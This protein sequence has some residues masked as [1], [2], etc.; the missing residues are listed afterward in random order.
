M[1][2]KII[3]ILNL[4]CNK[5]Y[6]QKYSFSARNWNSI[7]IIK[8]KILVELTPLLIDIFIYLTDIKISELYKDYLNE[9]NKEI[10]KGKEEELFIDISPK[11][12]ICPAHDCPLTILKQNLLILL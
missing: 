4:I 11:Y 8:F 7:Y 6:L 2:L 12:A 1:I 3:I 9:L 5:I 10:K